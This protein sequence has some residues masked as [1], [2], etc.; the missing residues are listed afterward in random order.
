MSSKIVASSVALLVS[1]PALA[2]L[3]GDPL[4][5][6][7]MQVSRGGLDAQAPFV[8]GGNHATVPQPPTGSFLL[9]SGGFPNG[10]RYLSVLE[11]LAATTTLTGHLAEFGFRNEVDVDPFASP[12]FEYA[13]AGNRLQF[14][15]EAEATFT[16]TGATQGAGS[17][18]VF[19]YDHADPQ[20]LRI[21]PIVGDQFL[22]SASFAAGSHTIVW[23]VLSDASGGMADWEGVASIFVVPAPGA[24][25]AFALAAIALGRRRR[26]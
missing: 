25:T 24:A 1:A 4:E 6:T 23:G 5:F 22:L 15:S 9:L 21:F 12:Q 10:D 16:A 19:L 2:D 20:G 13:F 14:T 11:Y 26:R 8:S 18:A 3:A 17:G 7:F